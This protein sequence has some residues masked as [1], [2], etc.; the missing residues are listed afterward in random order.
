[1]AQKSPCTCN[2]LDLPPIHFNRKRLNKD[3]HVNTLKRT[4]QHLAT[5]CAFERL[6]GWRCSLRGALLERHARQ[7]LG[8]C[9][10]TVLEADGES[11]RLWKQ[12]HLNFQNGHLWLRNELSRR[13]RNTIEREPLSLTRS[14]LEAAEQDPTSCWTP[15]TFFD[16]TSHPSCL[17]ARCLR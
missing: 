16:H 15:A 17:S 12:M 11:S 5:I 10:V 2:A 9:W 13:G 7:P 6:F 3:I 1:M 4:G 8:L 14:R